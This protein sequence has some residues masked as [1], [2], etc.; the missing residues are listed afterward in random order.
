[1]DTEKEI[2]GSVIVAMAGRAPAIRDEFI[3]RGLPH[4]HRDL[5]DALGRAA[6]DSLWD[7]NPT[8]RAQWIGPLRILVEHKL[9]K[10]ESFPA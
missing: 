10:P 5:V 1:M 2:F 7:S 4:S 8:V 6:L 3:K 9:S